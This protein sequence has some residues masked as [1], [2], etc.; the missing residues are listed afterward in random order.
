M[1]ELG[2]SFCLQFR[3]N[4][5]GIL[6]FKIFGEKAMSELLLIRT[7]LLI[8]PLIQYQALTLLLNLILIQCLCI[9]TFLFFGPIFAFF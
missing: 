9:W 2:F 1:Q 7:R 5:L 4:F 3:R 6:N 8:L